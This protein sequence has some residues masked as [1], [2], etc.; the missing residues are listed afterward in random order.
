MATKKTIKASL[1]LEREKM[2]K[3]KVSALRSF[4]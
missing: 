3:N 1:G 4:V 2:S